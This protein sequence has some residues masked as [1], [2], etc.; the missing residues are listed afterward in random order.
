MHSFDLLSLWAATL[1]GMAWKDMY[2]GLGPF[3]LAFLDWAWL[4]ALPW[5]CYVEM[6]S[7]P[8]LG[9]HAACYDLVGLYV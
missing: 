2:V 6:C 5:W 7:L 4:L 3:T 1:L 8:C 9:G